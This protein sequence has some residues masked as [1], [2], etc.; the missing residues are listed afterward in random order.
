MLRGLT[1]PKKVTPRCPE[2]VLNI[3]PPPAQEPPEK[4]FPRSVQ[5]SPPKRVHVEEE[6]R[7]SLGGFTSAKTQYIVDQQK[8]FGKSYNPSQ[9]ALSIPLMSH[10]L[11]TCEGSHW[12]G[13][14]DSLRL[15]RAMRRLT[16]WQ[17]VCSEAPTTRRA[18]VGVGARW[19]NWAFALRTFP[20]SCDPSTRSTS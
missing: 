3:P 13:R 18:V 5:Y 19:R 10:R 1:T 7:P 6:E 17:R 16:L 14:D 20:R 2:R 4:R 12:A 9:D 15:A 8:K 11:A